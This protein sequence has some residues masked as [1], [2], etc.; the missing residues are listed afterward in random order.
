MNNVTVGEWVQLTELPDWAH[1]LM[2]NGLE[3]LRFCVGKTFRVS[4]ITKDGLVQLDVSALV[5]PLFGRPGEGSSICVEKQYITLA[6][7]R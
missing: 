5:D 2:G 1:E 7:P 6:D 4:A 3:V